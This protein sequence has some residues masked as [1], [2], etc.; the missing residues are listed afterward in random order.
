MV[1]FT[2]APGSLPSMA[3]EARALD[4]MVIG[5]Q[6]SGTT[7]LHKYLQPHPALH[8]LP[9]KEAPFFSNDAWYDR[10]WPK[11]S[12]EFFANAPRDQLRAKVSPIYMAD[13]RVPARVHA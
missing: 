3:M 7:S 12:E 9:E 11:F 4:F 13:R 8:M 5:A 2:H 10:G 6:K 1:S